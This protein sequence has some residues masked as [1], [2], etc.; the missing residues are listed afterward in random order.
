MYPP[1]F[2]ADFKVG[3]ESSAI[4]SSNR[5]D[6]G[7]TPRFFFLIYNGDNEIKTYNL[8]LTTQIPHQ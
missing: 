7:V 2:L 3:P 8:M 4:S 6:I 1:R 5:V